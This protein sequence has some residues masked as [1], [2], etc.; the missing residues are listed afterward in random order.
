MNSSPNVKRLQRR[1]QDWGVC[2]AGISVA[3]GP[4][5]KK[6][7]LEVRSTHRFGE[8]VK[9]ASIAHVPEELMCEVPTIEEWDECIKQTIAWSTTDRSGKACDHKVIMKCLYVL[10]M[11]LHQQ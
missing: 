1:L 7:I 2:H 3:E 4:A 9:K 10:K 8:I 6:D 5:A 11:C